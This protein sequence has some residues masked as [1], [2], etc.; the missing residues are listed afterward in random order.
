MEIE[1]VDINA[2]GGTHTSSLAELQVRCP[3]SA[4]DDT[5]L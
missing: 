5:C 4:S 1:G 3:C 2:C